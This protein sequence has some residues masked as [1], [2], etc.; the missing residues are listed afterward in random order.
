MGELEQVNKQ[1]PMFLV[2]SGKKQVGKDTAANFAKDILNKH[3]L[4]V[5]ISAFAE[6]IK[7]FCNEVLGISYEL[8]NGTDEQK[9]SLTEYL[10]DNMP[11]DIRLRHYKK[12]FLGCKLSRKGP[13]T[14]RE[15]MQ[16]FGT[17]ICRTY[18]DYDL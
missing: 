4:S 10:W 12:T 2:M 5:T 9:N 14:V 7:Q 1:P 17:D 15:V 18:F 6:P 8:M 3:G 13:M 16:V 11:I